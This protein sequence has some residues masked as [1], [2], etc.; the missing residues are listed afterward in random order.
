MKSR[1][2]GG[3]ID[4]IYGSFD[5]GY[6]GSSRK[7]KPGE[8]ESRSNFDLS[9][10]LPY[11]DAPMGNFGHSIGNVGRDLN[12]LLNKGN[13]LFTL[14]NTI[15]SASNLNTTGDIAWKALEV[16]ADHSLGGKSKSILDHILD[17]NSRLLGDETSSKEEASRKERVIMPE[18]ERGRARRRSDS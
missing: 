1:S 18:A 9:S 15:A 14:G 8:P 13:K 5:L 4:E 2:D 10:D 11:P 17:G 6:D 3:Y 16:I 7:S 12:K